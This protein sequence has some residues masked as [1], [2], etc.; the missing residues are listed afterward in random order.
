MRRRPAPPVTDVFET[1]AHRVEDQGGH[2]GRRRSTPSTGS[3]LRSAGITVGLM[4]LTAVGFVVGAW[5][6]SKVVPQVG[7]VNPLWEGLAYLLWCTVWG[8]LAAGVTLAIG[9]VVVGLP[10]VRRQRGA[11]A[12]STSTP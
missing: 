6:A 10:W 11:G 7:W 8:A 1:F 9:V 3:V 5:L 12:T 2:R 4:A